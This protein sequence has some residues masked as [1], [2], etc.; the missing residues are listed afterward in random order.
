MT[1]EEHKRRARVLA[2]CVRYVERL[3]AFER[4]T[5]PTAAEALLD[6]HELEAVLVSSGMTL[7]AS[8]LDLV[9]LKARL[10]QALNVAPGMH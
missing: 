10:A 7:S 1:E 9:Q 3:K 6:L 5:A 8:T 4:G 2:D